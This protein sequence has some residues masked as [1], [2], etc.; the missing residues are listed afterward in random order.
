MTPFEKAHIVIAVNICGMIVA[1]WDL[2]HWCTEVTYLKLGESFNF[3]ASHR[4]TPQSYFLACLQFIRVHCT[5]TENTRPLWNRK[6]LHFISSNPNYMISKKKN[7]FT[8]WN[9]ERIRCAEHSVFT[10]FIGI[11]LWFWIF[12]LHNIRCIL[13]HKSNKS[14]AKYSNIHLL[15]SWIIAARRKLLDGKNVHANN[16]IKRE[17]QTYRQTHKCKLIYRTARQAVLVVP[18]IYYKR[19]IWLDYSVGCLWMKNCTISI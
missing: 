16:R 3:I 12:L 11:F 5:V 4:V 13:T 18:T 9:I 7:W 15:N 19:F 17:R 1:T 8:S 10:G 14:L 6:R 2:T